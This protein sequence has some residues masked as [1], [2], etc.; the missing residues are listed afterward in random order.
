MYDWVSSVFAH[1]VMRSQAAYNRDR[2]VFRASVLCE[3]FVPDVSD[4][5]ASW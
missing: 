1:L 2:S 3:C 4:S 5:W